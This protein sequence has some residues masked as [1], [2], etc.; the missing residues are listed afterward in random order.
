MRSVEVHFVD[1]FSS[2]MVLVEEVSRNL[3]PSPTVRAAANA[4]LANLTAVDG[5]FNGV[6]LRVEDDAPYKA[7]AGGE[8]VC[9]AHTLNPLPA[10]WLLWHAHKSQQP[11]RGA[12]PLSEHLCV[13]DTPAAKPAVNLSYR[14]CQRNFTLSPSALTPVPRWISNY[15]HACLTVSTNRMIEL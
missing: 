1:P 6:H 4:I 8:Q 12:F 9:G 10:I 7:S 2:H 13:L 3:R 14:R 15:C 11:R 5:A